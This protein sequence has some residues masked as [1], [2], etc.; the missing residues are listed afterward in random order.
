MMEVTKKERGHR[1]VRDEVTRPTLR[2]V[3]L[4]YYAIARHGQD[5]L[6]LLHVPLGFDEKALVTFSQNLQRRSGDLG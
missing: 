2:P 4:H 6:R 1:A 3:L 5:D